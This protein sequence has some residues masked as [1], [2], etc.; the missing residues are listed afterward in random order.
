MS[1]KV[2]FTTPQSMFPCCFS[3]RVKTD[4]ANFLIQE[5]YS[6]KFNQIQNKIFTKLFSVVQKLWNRQ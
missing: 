4:M 1:Q 6:Y 5:G 3:R 2:Y